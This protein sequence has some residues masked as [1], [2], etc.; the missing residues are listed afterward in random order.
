[1]V[2]ISFMASRVERTNFDKKTGFCH[3]PIAVQ[4]EKW[5]CMLQIQEALKE[6]QVWG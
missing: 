2:N 5:D 3:H 1:L 6:Q 4:W